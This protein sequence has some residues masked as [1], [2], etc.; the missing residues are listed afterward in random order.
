[1]RAL[2]FMT[3]IRMPRRLLR[4]SLVSWLYGAATLA[5]IA[6]AGLAA[7]SVFLTERAET[8]AQ[9]IL[10]EWRADDLQIDALLRSLSEQRN[11]VNRLTT[12]GSTDTARIGLEK[13][14]KQLRQAATTRAVANMAD[15]QPDISRLFGTE[16]QVLSLSGSGAPG[17]ETTAAQDRYA[18]IAA[19]LQTKLQ[20]AQDERLQRLLRQ[21]GTLLAHSRQMIGW[22]WVSIAAILVP[23]TIGLSIIHNFYTNAKSL[24]RIMRRLVDSDTSVTICSDGGDDILSQMAEALQAFKA[25][26]IATIRHKEELHRINRHFDIALRNMSHG[27]CMYDAADR[28]IIANPRFHEIYGMDPERIRIG[29]SFFDILEYSVSLGNYPGRSPEDVHA[30]RHAFITKREP[31]VFVQE[32]GDGGVVAITH[33]PMADGGWVAIY[34]DITERRRA[35]RQIAQLARYDTLTGLPNRMLFRERLDHALTQTQRG[36][37]IGLHCLDLDQFKAVNDTLGHPLGDVLLRAVA[38]RLLA[39]VREGDTVARLG[40]DE[41][42][43]IQTGLQN[44]DDASLLATRILHVTS[45]PYEIEGQHLLSSLSIGIAMAPGDTSDPDTLLRSAD[46]ALYRAKAAGRATHCFFETGMNVHL[47]ARRT[48][49]LDL[50]QALARQEFDLHYQPLI[51]LGSG[52]ISGFEALLR[53]HHPNRGLVS[54]GE[55][56]PDC[57]R[58]GLIIQIGEWALRRACTDAAIWPKDVKVAVNLSPTQFRT[59]NLVKTVTEALAASGLPPRQLDLEITESVLLLESELTC[60]ILHRL[61]GLGVCISL[62]DFGTGYSSLSYLRNFPFDKIKIDQSFVRDLTE[63][64]DAIA[65]VRAVTALGRSLGMTT[66][67]E[68]VETPEQL[69]SLRAEGCT[70]AQGYLFSR[71]V[72]A[73]EVPSLLRESLSLTHDAVDRP[74]MLRA[75]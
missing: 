53:W 31:G 56:I 61:R 71:P 60:Q 39:C 68:G 6:L 69:A 27:L 18:A 5:L 41:F 19:R 42:A 4:L 23:G 62:D 1:M 45:E 24:T 47:Q 25:N 30:E 72:P 32:M 34:E 21:I 58:I 11:I 8:I 7:V 26:T 46:M 40:G 16:R 29:D 51:N 33:R 44:F 65:I 13:L 20:D 14:D 70:E 59:G 55:F 35:E 9:Q 12:A 50:R 43:I 37:H 15:I 74:W 75:T 2:A 28:L 63:Q 36:H 48:M 17:A 10:V 66:V 64:K 57:E 49:E 73:S 22:I 67:A 54:P 52:Q 38:E 3:L